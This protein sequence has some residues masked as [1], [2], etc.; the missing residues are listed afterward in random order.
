MNLERWRELMRALRIGANEGTF[1]AIVAAYE[2]PHR[3]YHGA[4]H[5][6]DCLD[7][8]DRAPGIAERTEDVEA[9]LWF[10]DVVYDVR[11][12]TNELRSAERAAAFLR[13]AGAGPDVA[14]RVYDLVLATKHGDAALVGD[15]AAVVDVDL[16][17]LGRDEATYDAFE[18][19]IREE[20]AWVP[21]PLYR[22]KRA[23][24]LASF[25]ERARVYSTDVFRDR[26]E[27]RARR[28]LERAIRA[29]RGA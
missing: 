27:A 13:D 6:E 12:T 4:A 21:E 19:A 2:E 29:L 3:R 22:D 18:R 17:I 14:R 24:I 9:A 25:L 20:Y 28:N 26:F 10:H 15:A 7:Q 8:L 11:S 23:E 5:I 16:S 1:A